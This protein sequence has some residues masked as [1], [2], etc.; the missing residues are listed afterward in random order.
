[1]MSGRGSQENC[2][3]LETRVE[4]YRQLEKHRGH[5]L[6]V[7]VTST[8][9]S[10][11]AQMAGDV[12][13][14]LISQ[15]QALPKDTDAVDLLIVSNGG[16]PTVACRI[17]SLVRERVKKL[18]VLV[19]SVAF[20]AATLVALG[21]D[22][23]V[24]HAFGNLG[25][26]DPQITGMRPGPNGQPSQIHFG[27]ED[28]SAFLAFAKNKVGLTDQ[29]QL[30]SVF[31]MFC[32]EVGAAAIGVAARGS[33]LSVS[34]GHRLLQMH[35]KG[36]G[37]EQKVKAITKKL[38]EEFFHHGYALG[39]TE[40][41][42]IG[43]KVKVPDAETE[44]LMWSIWTDIEAEMQLRKAFS[45]F[46]YLMS[47]P[48]AKALF[49]PVTLPVLP[50]GFAGPGAMQVVQIP[51]IPFE[52]LQVIVESPRLA[53][54][55]K[56]R[57]L[58]LASRTP[59]MKVP[60]NVMQTGLYWENVG[61]PQPPPESPPASPSQQVEFKGGTISARSRTKAVKDSAQEAAKP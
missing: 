23:I 45:P 41:Q 44:R 38:S 12:V 50:S 61:V 2:M 14:E 56:M 9:P 3:S 34:M 11:N 24:M 31:D 22:E 13:G 10:W 6:I 39:R 16:D 25:P 17:V 40:A 15:L 49:E 26:V 43:L 51:S 5:P 19:P 18:S 21:A 37:Q 30:A 7:Y 48:A 55:E 46:E 8:R 20:S 29:T 58:I 52:L 42:G 59:D 4:L 28:L 53:S 35:M 54:W 36:G 27:S 47:N 57:G 60:I 1:M 32:K 33:Q